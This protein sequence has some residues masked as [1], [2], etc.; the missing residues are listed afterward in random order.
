MLHACTLP[1]HLCNCPA[2]TSNVSTEAEAG[3][4]WQPGQ[5]QLLHS[6]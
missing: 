5:Y 3:Y 1:V 2:A 4:V 6:H